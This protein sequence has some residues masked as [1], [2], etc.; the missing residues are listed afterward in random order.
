MPLTDMHKRYELAMEAMGEIVE[1]LS[2][3]GSADGCEV[4][5][6]VQAASRFAND[7]VMCIAKAIEQ[8]VADAQLPTE[9]N[10]HPDSTA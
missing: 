9:T 10:E 8:A 7:G 3:I 1:G 6:H 5:M 4:S 2:R